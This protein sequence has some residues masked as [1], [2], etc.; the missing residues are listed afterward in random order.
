MMPKEKVLMRLRVR[1][2]ERRKE[3]S[4]QTPR[5]ASKKE[6]GNKANELQFLQRRVA[7]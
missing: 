2:E 5:T 4:E 3:T 1:K 7:P 6:K